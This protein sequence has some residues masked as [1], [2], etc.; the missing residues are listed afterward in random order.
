MCLVVGWA[1][2]VSRVDFREDGSFS[3]RLPR[4]RGFLPYFGIQRLDGTW[5]DVR[6]LRYR[7]VRS[8]LVYVGYDYVRHS[9]V[10]AQGSIM[11]LAFERGDLVR[12]TRSVS[13]NIPVA[14]AMG[15]FR[16]RTG[17]S[18]VEEPEVRGGG[19]LRNLL[20]GGPA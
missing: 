16:T 8:S 19:L 11:M 2:F 6:Q 17:L 5:K 9:I 15:L 1:E 7:R 3:I 18:P 14:E 20:L 10:T 12:N 4:Y 13:Q